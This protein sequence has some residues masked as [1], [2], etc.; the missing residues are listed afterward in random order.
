MV[1]LDEEA[2]V[3]GSAE[4]GEDEGEA[5]CCAGI[6]DL[7]ASGDLATAGGSWREEGLPPSYELTA[8]LGAG[9]RVF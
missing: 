3:G 2:A 9:S 7:R 5:T 6:E 4:E 1:E 8:G